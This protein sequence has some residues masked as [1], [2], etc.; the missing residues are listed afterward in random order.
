MKWN[1]LNTPFNINE[2]GSVKEVLAQRCVEKLKFMEHHLDGLQMK[3]IFQ[4]DQIL[5]LKNLINV[6]INKNECDC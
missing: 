3:L 6:Y 2:N 5:R 4:H 1:E